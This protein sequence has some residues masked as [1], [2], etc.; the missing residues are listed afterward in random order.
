LQ[1]TIFLGNKTMSVSRDEVLWAFRSILGREPESE[2][3]IT[4]HMRCSDFAALRD[5]LLNSVEFSKIMRTL[6]VAADI[7]VSAARRN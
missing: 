3:T 4:L 7:R 5:A 1:R 6:P 2:N